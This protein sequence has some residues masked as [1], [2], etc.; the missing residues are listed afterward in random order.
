M[1][2]WI[3]QCKM[4]LILKR[5]YTIAERDKELNCLNE[6]LSVGLL[7]SN[8]SPERRPTMSDIMGALQNIKEIFLRVANIPKFQVDITSL[9]GSTSTS[10]PHT[11]IG[12]SQSSSTF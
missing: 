5:T 8:E 10:T 9:L 11:N 3:K 4:L 7:S 6:L 1:P 2:T 12:K